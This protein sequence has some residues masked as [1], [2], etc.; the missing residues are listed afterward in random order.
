MMLAYV[1][2]LTSSHPLDERLFLKNTNKKREIQE[3]AS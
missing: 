1:A 3:Q 2:R